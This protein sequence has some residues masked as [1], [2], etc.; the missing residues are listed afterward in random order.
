MINRKAFIRFLLINVLFF[1]LKGF[2]V[3]QQ[4]DVP[5]PVFMNFSI[6]P[7]YVP[8]YHGRDPLRP[9][10]NVERSPEISVSDLDYHGVIYIGKEPVALFTWRGNPLVQY[11]LKYRKLYSG[12]DKTI[13]GV[14]GD[15]SN[16]EV[17]LIQGEQKIVYS[18]K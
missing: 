6:Q 12:G 15:I 4:Q 11:T 17:V 2:V 3:A 14:V 10:D 5:E 16:S 13:D 1:L 8:T 9:L 18:R 7:L